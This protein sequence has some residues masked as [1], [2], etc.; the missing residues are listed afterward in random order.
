[1]TIR[2][3]YLCVA[4]IPLLVGCAP[5]VDRL[6]TGIGEN[7]RTL[8]ELR[9]TQQQMRQDLA[10][11]YSFVKADDGGDLQQRAALQERLARIERRL[12]QIDHKLDDNAEFMRTIS[13]RVDMLATRLGVPTL[14]E[15]KALPDT[16]VGSDLVTLPEEGRAI[17]RAALLDRSRG[18]LET[19]REGFQDFLA[20]YGR[21]ELADDA[22]YWLADIA[23]SAGDDRTAL[24]H[25]QRLLDAHPASDRRPD[26]LLMAVQAARALGQAEEA[27]RYLDE[28]ERR[29]PDAEQTL[30]A[31]Q[32]LADTAGTTSGD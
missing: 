24:E 3:R 26:A 11:L 22:L 32:A 27:A 16:V 13:A 23:H 8:A 21:S 31:R 25:L 30:L 5:R 12:E 7:A 15:Y 4:C 10:G 6:E 9:R 14:G 19:A 17:Y 29:W 28:L 20:S 1:M 2:W 18:N